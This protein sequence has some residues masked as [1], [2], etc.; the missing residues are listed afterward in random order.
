[1]AGAL[2]IGQLVFFHSLL[3]YLLDPL[4]RLSSVNLELQD[5]LV[6]VDRLFQITDLPP[7]SLGDARK[8]RFA[9]VKNAIELRN[10]TFRYGC[11]ANVLDGTS[12]S[13]P[14]GQTVAIVGESGSGKSTLL[15]LLMGFYAPTEGQ[16]LID[17]I[18]QRDLDLASLRAGIGLVS[19]DAF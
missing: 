19:Q 9:G 12:L 8:A 6:A 17:G 2:T 14:A 13:V 3:G 15:K 16:V 10:V 11:R 4:D 7:E 1:M 18:D 5:A